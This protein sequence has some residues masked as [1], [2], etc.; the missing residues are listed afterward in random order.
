M[1][2]FIIKSDWYLKS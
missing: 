1:T 2:S